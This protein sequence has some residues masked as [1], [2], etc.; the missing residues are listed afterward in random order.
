[1]EREYAKQQAVLLTP[2]FEERKQHLGGET[3]A[4]WDLRPAVDR[5]A[6][7]GRQE[8]PD[9]GGAGQQGVDAVEDAAVAGEEGAY[10]LDGEVALDHRLGQVAEDCCRE[11]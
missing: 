11:S 2:M 6:D 3:L 4:P 1:M 5:L 9:H 10:V 7:E 8:E